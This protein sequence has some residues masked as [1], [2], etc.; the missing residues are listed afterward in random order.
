MSK[1]KNPHMAKT[2]PYKNDPCAEDTEKLILLVKEHG[3]NYQRL[4]EEFG[5]TKTREQL[6][7]MIAFLKRKMDK[8]PW[9]KDDEFYTKICQ[10]ATK[11]ETIVK[12]ESE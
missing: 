12:V 2:K 11:Y 6:H 5:G 1:Y 3:K 4:C 7:R 10:T 9:L 8:R